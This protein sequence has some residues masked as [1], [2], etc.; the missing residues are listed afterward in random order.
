MPG[1]PG[2]DPGPALA[3]FVAGIRASRIPAISSRDRPGLEPGSRRSMLSSSSNHCARIGA[4]VAFC[5]HEVDLD[6]CVRS[7]IAEATSAQDP[8]HWS[9]DRALE[10]SD[11]KAKV[12]A[13]TDRDA[14]T[15][16]GIQA[17][18]EQDAQGVVKAN[19]ECV[20]LPDKSWVRPPRRSTAPCC[21]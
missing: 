6:P 10:W 19:V 17:S 9:A 2:L 13:G 15:Y 1:H 5:G 4:V 7:P 20:F 18:W 8:I 21:S 12:P 14:Y 11:F 16:Y 3:F